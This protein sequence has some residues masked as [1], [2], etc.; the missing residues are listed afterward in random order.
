MLVR[1]EGQLVSWTEVSASGR[2]G[3]V[4]GSDLTFFAI[5]LDPFVAQLAESTLLPPYSYSVLIRALRTAPWR[6]IRHDRALV[7]L[8]ESK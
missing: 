1:M 7:C 5:V 4:Q 8:A 6:T 2:V 3:R